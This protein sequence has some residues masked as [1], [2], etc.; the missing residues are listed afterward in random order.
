MEFLLDPNVAYLL[1]VGGVLLGLLAIIS[2]GTGLLEVG[3][4]FC[5]LL[6]AYAIYNI[7]LIR[8]WALLI[9]A[10][11]F[12]PLYFAWRNILRLPM[13]GLS[14]LLV[15]AG[16]VFLF[17]GEDNALIGVNPI[18]AGVVSLLIGGLIWLAFTKVV[19]AHRTRRAHD[20]GVLIGQ[21]GEARTEIHSEGSVQV[22]GE[23]WSARSDKPIA[24][25]RSV[26]IVRREGFTLIVESFEH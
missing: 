8:W 16:S 10:A 14:I 22:A 12:A 23:L 15:I 3:A 19:D 1:L 9:L 25:G 6:A 17:P 21:V 20:L 26:R 24:A 5:L 4:G 11:S 7:D 18:L 2:P 13:L